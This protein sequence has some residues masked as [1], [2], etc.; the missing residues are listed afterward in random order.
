VREAPALLRGGDRSQELSV[1][2]LLLMGGASPL[3]RVL[4]PRPAGRLRVETIP[5]AGH[6][7]PEE[8]PAAV[9]ERALPFLHDANRRSRP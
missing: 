4:D 8:A 9:L 6:F 3:R 2:T 5:G 7:L 1:D